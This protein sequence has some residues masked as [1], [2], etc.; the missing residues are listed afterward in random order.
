MVRI[1]R[2]P[3]GDVEDVTVGDSRAEIFDVEASITARCDL[4]QLKTV[5]ADGFPE[6]LILQTA[7]S[8]GLETHLFNEIEIVSDDGRP[9]LR[10]IC[11]HPNKYWEG[12]WGLA[13]S[14]RNKTPSLPRL[15]M[16]R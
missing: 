5:T 8:D 16:P 6:E 13:T 12:R 10:F 4:P 1:L 7:P 11:Q 14:C 15:T 3:D 9:S 2:N